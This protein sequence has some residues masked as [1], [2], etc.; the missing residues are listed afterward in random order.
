MLKWTKKEYKIRICT[1]GSFVSR[2]IGCTKMYLGVQ[3]HIL[4]LFV[5]FALF[6]LFKLA[7]WPKR[8]RQ[9]EGF[10][11]IS[12]RSISL[13]ISDNFTKNREILKKLS[14]KVLANFAILFSKMISK[15]FSNF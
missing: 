3:F 2:R 12:L 11:R 14:S 1:L 9:S 8:T 13:Q 5:F 15:I 7:G 10:R 6:A 4:Y